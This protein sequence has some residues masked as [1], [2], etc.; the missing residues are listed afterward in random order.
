MKARKISA[1]ERAYTRTETRLLVADAII[2]LF[3]KLADRG[4]IN[5][6]RLAERLGVSRAYISK[7]LT[8]PGNW[9][10]DTVGDLLAAMDSR[11]TKIEADK[12]EN[13]PMSNRFYNLSQE[14]EIQALGTPHTIK[15][16]HS[17]TTMQFTPSSTS[18]V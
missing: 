1:A 6:T 7:Q 11:L 13:I 10:L 15:P 9:T 4:E 12:V 3:R 8:S 18:N 5:Q 17:S 2:A 16:R 14:N